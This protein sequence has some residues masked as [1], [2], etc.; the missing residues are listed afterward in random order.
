MK[1]V[2]DLDRMKELIGRLN[3]AS[4]NY[5]NGLPE[6]MSDHEW[7]ALFDELQS[8]EKATGE[9]L[10]DSPTVNVSRD[11]TAGKKVE[12]EYPALSLAKTKDVNELFKWAEN[13]PVWLSWKLDGLTLVAT[14]DG[15]KL[16]RLVTRGNGHIGTDITHLSGAINGVLQN[17]DHAGHL[18]IRGEAVIS[19]K[20]FEEF[21]TESKEDYANPRNLA[22]GSLSLK[23]IDEVKRRRINFIPFTLVHCDEEIVSWGARMDKLSALGFQTVERELIHEP[24]LSNINDAIERW[25]R[26][27]TSN[28]NPYPVDGLV[29]G[30]DDTVYAA[31]GSV[32]GHHATRAGFAFKWA[33]EAVESTLSYI[34]WSCAAGSITPVA[35]FEPVALEGTTVKRASLCNISECERLSIGGKGTILSVIKANKIIPK[36]I[37]VKE[38]KGELII[39]ETCPVCGEKTYI[40]VSEISGTKTLRCSNEKCP[41]KQ[42]RKFSRFVSKEGMDIDGISE[43]TLQRFVNLGWIHELSDILRLPEHK[44]EIAALDGFGEKSADNIKASVEKAMTVDADKFIFALSI[45]LVGPDV[46]KRLLSAYG[47]RGLFETAEKTDDETV[48]SVIDGI[49]SE[50]SSA[51]VRWVK[52]DE[53]REVLSKLMQLL[54]IKEKEKAPAGEKCKGLTFVIT[55]D[56]FKFKNRAEVKAYIESQGGVVTGSVSKKTSFL[57]NNDAESTSNKNQKARELSIPIISEDEFIERFR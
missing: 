42:L 28:E 13:R 44:D 24:S 25:T 23:D 55:G 29:A 6:L 20:D 11:D 38:K 54:T 12:H 34:E 17:I 22:S 2:S 1:K 56:V 16:S 27:V 21:M 9:V 40:R 53:N 3:A 57:I 15:G 4:D 26:K 31:G 49:G 18:V 43:M 36:V 37:E 41:A 46:A 32:T 14:Y 5:Y 33:D 30:Y 39:P 50:K 48:F 19:Y 35:V 47:I 45:P 51:F 7:D 8:L 52:E 10:P